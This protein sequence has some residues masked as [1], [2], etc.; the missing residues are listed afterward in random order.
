LKEHHGLELRVAQAVIAMAHN[1]SEYRERENIRIRQ[2]TF[3]V[4]LRRRYR[5]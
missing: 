4:G 3:R 2:T 5:L 1:P